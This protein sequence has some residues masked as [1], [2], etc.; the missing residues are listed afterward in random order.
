MNKTSIIV[1]SFLLILSSAKCQSNS[2]NNIDQLNWLEGKWIRTNSKAGQSG[3]ELWSRV[4]SNELSGRGV[5]LKGTD[6]LF[7][8]KLRIVVR[9]GNLHYVADVP[10][11]KMPVY[12]PFVELKKNSFVCENPDHDFPKRISYSLEGTTLKAT[13]SGDGKSIHYLFEKK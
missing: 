11:N 6:T 13:I 10:E 1:I 5:T 3:F 9:D 12:F 2:N 4:S 7:V 8:E